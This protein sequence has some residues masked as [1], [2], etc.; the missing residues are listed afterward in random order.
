MH[1]LSLLFVAAVALAGCKKKDA[2]GGADC[3][4]AID[5]SMELSKAE[6]SKMPGVDDKMLAKMRDLGVTRCKE[7]GWPDEARKCMVDAKTMADA[8]R[9]AAGASGRPIAGAR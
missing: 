7:D 8:R 5:H 1:K 2:A 4:K 6:M 3:D 9:V